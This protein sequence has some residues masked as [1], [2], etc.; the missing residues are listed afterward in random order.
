MAMIVPRQREKEK[1][2][3]IGDFGRKTSSAARKSGEV[4]GRRG[5]RR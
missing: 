3:P 4:R 1:A 5:V 2:M